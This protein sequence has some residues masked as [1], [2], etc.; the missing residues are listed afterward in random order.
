MKW[1]LNEFKETYRLEKWFSDKV[2]VFIDAPE[3]ERER[4]RDKFNV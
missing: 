2:F 1:K 4:E 3:S